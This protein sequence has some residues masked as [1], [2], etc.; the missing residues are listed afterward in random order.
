MM[1]GRKLRITIK[2]DKTN[3]T[4]MA[5]NVSPASKRKRPSVKKKPTAKKRS[6]PSTNGT[7]GYSYKGDFGNW[8][9]M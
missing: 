4:L 3:K 7:N 9:V 8:K 5:F 2:D 6:K 1:R